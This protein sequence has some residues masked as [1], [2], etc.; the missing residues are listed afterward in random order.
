[1]TLQQLKAFQNL[2]VYDNHFNCSALCKRENIL[3]MHLA[4]KK[5]EIFPEE[6]ANTLQVY[7]V[8]RGIH[9]FFSTV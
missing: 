4:K 6:R 8:H 9:N 3:E 7:L 5:L 1:M 2:F